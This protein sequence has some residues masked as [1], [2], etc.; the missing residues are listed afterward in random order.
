V[1]DNI[2]EMIEAIPQIGKIRSS[3]CRRRVEEYFSPVRMA[4][5]YLEAY[6]RILLKES[7]MV[8]MV[9]TGP[10]NIPIKN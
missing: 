10:P 3:D 6:Q 2:E 9:N 7:R 1:T 4:N 8:P 5:D